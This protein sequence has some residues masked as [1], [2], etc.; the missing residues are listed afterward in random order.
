[1]HAARYNESPEVVQVLGA[2]VE[3][4]WSGFGLAAP[5]EIWLLV[6][7]HPDVAAS[8]G[9]YL[10]VGVV[11]VVAGSV[12]TILGKFS[13]SPGRPRQQQPPS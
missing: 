3:I 12:A 2:L 11:A 4:A 7:A 8:S 13:P 1:M 6:K 9:L 10:L 5:V